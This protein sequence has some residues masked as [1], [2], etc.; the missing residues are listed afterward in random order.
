LY[1]DKDSI[2]LSNLHNE[3]LPIESV[4]PN[5]NPVSENFK[6]VIFLSDEF[7]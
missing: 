5:F 4:D 6:E 3:I 1:G 7:L 2:V